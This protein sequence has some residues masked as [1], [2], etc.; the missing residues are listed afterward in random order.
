MLSQCPDAFLL[1]AN[2]D[3]GNYCNVTP[4]FLSGNRRVKVKLRVDGSYPIQHLAF[5]FLAFHPYCVMGTTRPTLSLGYLGWGHTFPGPRCGHLT[6]GRTRGRLHSF[7]HSVWLRLGHVPQASPARLKH[8]AFMPTAWRK[9]FFF[10]EDRQQEH[11]G[12]WTQ[13]PK[14]AT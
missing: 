13:L 10:H 7:G 14:P 12:I 6:R 1:V 5:I 11:V 2:V 9:G 8:G 4:S 3:P